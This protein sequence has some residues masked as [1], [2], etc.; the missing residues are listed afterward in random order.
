MV[1]TLNWRSSA[2]NFWRMDDNL[3]NF[4]NSE[5]SNTS[6]LDLSGFRIH[7]LNELRICEESSRGISKLLNTQ[8][9]EWCFEMYVNILSPRINRHIYYLK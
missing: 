5:T 7:K 9:S 4:V 3:M 6:L 1:N 8:F 2:N